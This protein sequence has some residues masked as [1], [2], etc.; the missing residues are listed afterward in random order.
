MGLHRV[1]RSDELPLPTMRVALDMRVR[2]EARAMTVGEPVI[3]PIRVGAAEA[4]VTRLP[5]GRVVAFAS[6]C[7]HQGTPLWRATIYEGTLRC[8]QHTYLYDLTSGAN[9]FPTLG[10]SPEALFRLKP[11]SLKIYEVEER[12]GWVW[13]SDTPKAAPAAYEP[14]GDAPAILA[15]LGP[16][17]LAVAQPTEPVDHPVQEVQ[18]HVDDELEIA[19]PTNPVP[20]H[21]WRYELSSDGVTI[22]GQRFEAGALAVTRIVARGEVVGRVTLRC[23]Y[24]KPW[25]QKALETRTYE[26]AVTH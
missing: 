4:L 9:I 19:I 15:A 13:V 21:I 2:R 25:G 3:V 8:P 22:V 6:H 11:G 14:A 18:L 1:V 24:A 10:A 16:S 17:T 20:G 7:P 26:I 12:D 5:S 23:I